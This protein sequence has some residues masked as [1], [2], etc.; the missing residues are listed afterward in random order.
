MKDFLIETYRIIVVKMKK[1]GYVQN[2]IIST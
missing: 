1:T 2:W